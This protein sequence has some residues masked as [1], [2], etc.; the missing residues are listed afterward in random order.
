MSRLLV[1]SGVPP[2]PLRRTCPAFLSACFRTCLFLTWF[3]WNAPVNLSAVCIW[4]W[5]CLI[6]CLPVLE[7]KFYSIIVSL[8]DPHHESWHFEWVRLSGN[9]LNCCWRLRPN[10][11]DAVSQRFAELCEWHVRLNLISQ[12]QE[13]E[14][15]LNIEAFICLMSN[16]KFCPWTHSPWFWEGWRMK[17]LERACKQDGHKLGFELWT[18]WQCCLIKGLLDRTNKL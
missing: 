10:A 11:S 17:T 5:D 12:K 15:L 18:L 6:L 14:A 9:S 16:S 2:S 7:F 1:C 4:Q 13:Q 3:C 8:L